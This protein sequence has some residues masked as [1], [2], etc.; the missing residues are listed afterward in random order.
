MRV[1]VLAIAS[2]AALAFSDYALADEVMTDVTPQPIAMAQPI[3]STVANDSKIVI[4]HHLIHEGVLMPQQECLTKRSW[5]RMRQDTMKNVSDFQV[6]SF[7]TP[8]K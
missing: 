5:E 7:S 4:C 8:A 6:H 1:T 2:V 3:S